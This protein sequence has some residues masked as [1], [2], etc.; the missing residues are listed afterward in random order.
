MGGIYLAQSL[1]DGNRPERTDDGNVADTNQFSIFHCI[2]L[3][4]RVLVHCSECE[5]IQTSVWTC[6]CWHYACKESENA[7]NNGMGRQLRLL[8]MG[9]FL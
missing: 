9:I 4:L 8:E 7:G 6:K 5:M 2:I 1:L 3:L